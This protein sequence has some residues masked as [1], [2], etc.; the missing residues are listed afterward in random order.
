MAS[1]VKEKFSGSAA[2]TITLAS[3]AS[4]VV[5][6]GRQS[7]MVDNSSDRFGRIT[8]YVRVRVGTSP[9][10]ARS[11]RVYL[12]RSDKIASGT[13]HRSDN[14]GASDAG[15]TV[16]NATLVGVLYVDAATSDLDY[17][18]EIVVDAPGPEWGVAIVQD[19]G[20]NLNS[21]GTN[22]WVRFV[23]SNPENQ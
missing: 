8:L 12:I 15:L 3:L 7:T 14:A 19:T 2:L 18:A 9:T 17:Y 6:V 11:I 21:T 22:H 10:A 13:I 23:G 16:K 5:G 20:V 4:S 1:E